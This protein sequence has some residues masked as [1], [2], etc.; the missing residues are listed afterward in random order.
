MRA[1]RGE[2]CQLITFSPESNAG[3][4]EARRS[5]SKRTLAYKVVCGSLHYNP[6]VKDYILSRISVYSGAHGG[7]HTCA[8]KGVWA[9]ICMQPLRSRR[10]RGSTAVSGRLQNRRALLIPRA[11]PACLVSVAA[12]SRSACRGRCRN[13]WRRQISWQTSRGFGMTGDRECPHNHYIYKDVFS[14][15]DTMDTQLSSLLAY[16]RFKEQRQRS[17]KV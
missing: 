15:Q 7:L 10:T 4:G 6:R 16:L 11:A 17:S 5:R 9:Q 1:R 8:R 3:A 12:G 2:S 14:I 13:Y